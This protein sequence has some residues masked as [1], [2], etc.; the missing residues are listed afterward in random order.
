VP[1]DDGKAR[2]GEHLRAVPD[3]PH[4]LPTLIAGD[5][6]DPEVDPWEVLG[7]ARIG[8]DLRKRAQ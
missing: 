6:E 8:K 3:P 1:D 5:D 2:S 7:A 4:V